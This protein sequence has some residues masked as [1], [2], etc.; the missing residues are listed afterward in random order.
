MAPGLRVCGADKPRT[1]RAG[2]HKPRATEHAGRAHFGIERVAWYR[3]E[4][5]TDGELG[6]AQGANDIGT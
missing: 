3:V 2:C 5:R 6:D 4:S 1:P